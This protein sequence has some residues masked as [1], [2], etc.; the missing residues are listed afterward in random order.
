MRR[1]ESLA[2]TA[3]LGALALAALTGCGGSAA[4]QASRTDH[5][6][7]AAQSVPLDAQTGH[8]AAAGGGGGG[9][10]VVS[11]P[12]DWPAS[13]PVPVGTLTATSGAVNHW[14]VNETVKG[15]D[16]VVIARIVKLYQNRRFVQDTAFDNPKVLKRGRFTV[17]VYWRNRDHGP[18]AT[19]VLLVLDKR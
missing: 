14:T 8:R 6:A 11:L 9:T 18:E 17:T 1:T 7:L 12:A 10:P 15:V 5:V 2:T 19:E 4:Q 3:A 13:V 16:T